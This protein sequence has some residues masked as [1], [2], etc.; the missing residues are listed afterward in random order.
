[1]NLCAKVRQGRAQSAIMLAI[2]Y[3]RQNFKQNLSVSFLASKAHMSVSSFHRRF[4]EVTGLSPL[5]FHK[6]IRLHQA[7]L[8]LTMQK[9]TVAEIAYEIGYESQSQFIRDYRRHFGKTPGQELKELLLK[10]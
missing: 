6:Q 3:M 4:K 5:Q 1:M 7:K 9:H 10:T 8:M 2:A